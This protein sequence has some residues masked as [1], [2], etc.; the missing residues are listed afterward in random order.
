MRKNEQQLLKEALGATCPF[1]FRMSGSKLSFYSDKTDAYH[2]VLLMLWAEFPRGF[3]DIPYFMSKYQC[4]AL[5][6]AERICGQFQY[7]MIKLWDTDDKDRLPLLGKLCK[8]LLKV[9]G[10]EFDENAFKNA[11]CRFDIFLEQSHIKE[12]TETG[13]LVNF[14]Q[15]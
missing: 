9:N 10:V 15:K 14:I 5:K 7:A 13:V 12:Q 8:V 4:V 6:D 2:D 3:I 1:A 11:V